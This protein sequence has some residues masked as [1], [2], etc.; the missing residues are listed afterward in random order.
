MLIFHVLGNAYALIRSF[1]LLFYEQSFFCA[2]L[3]G[4]KLHMVLPPS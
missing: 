2:L 1:K 4:F 3:Q